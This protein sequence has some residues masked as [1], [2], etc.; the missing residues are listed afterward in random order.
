[1]RTTTV[2]TSAAGP[3]RLLATTVLATATITLLAALPTAQAQTSSVTVTVPASANVEAT[4]GEVP[5]SSLPP[6]ELT[7]ALSHLGGFESIPPGTLQEALTKL[8][9]ELSAKGSTLQSLLGGGEAGTMLK[10]RLDE[11]LGSAASSVEALLGSN[12]L[13]GLTGAL[14]STTPSEV[15]G[16]LLAGSSDPQSLIAQ[17]LGAL[18]PEKLQSLLG[19]T[20]SGQPF[21]TE[22]LEQLAKG[23]GL[24]PEALVSAL[25]EPIKAL[26]GGAS[27]LTTPL[28][29]GETLDIVPSGGTPGPGGTGGP[30]GSATGTPGGPSSVTLFTTTTSPTTAA[31]AAKTGKLRIVSQKIKGASAT[32]VVEVPSAGKLSA[33]GKNLRTISRETAKAERVTIHPALTKARSSAL[34]KHHRKLKVPVK[35]SF[36]QTGGPS[37]SVTVQLTYK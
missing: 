36:K 25:G 20:L 28:A 22:T 18:S 3:L 6:A 2:R 32:I 16:T 14:G 13:T 21:L 33:G 10:A 29:N 8:I 30:G 15:I 5:V 7:E 34:R 23:L 26:V 1:M 35:V 9:D 27:A 12:P 37:S 24:N 19:S 4:L 31:A 11:L 17:I